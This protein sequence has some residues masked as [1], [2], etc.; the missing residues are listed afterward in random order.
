MP[1]RDDL[2]SICIVGSGPIVIGQACRVRLRRLPG[3]EGAA[4]GRLPHDRRQLEPGHDH[5]RPRLRRPHVP[6]AARPRG[7]RRGAAARAA[8]RAAADDGR[9]DGP[10]PR[11]RARDRRRPRRARR[12]ADRGGA[13]RDRARRGPAALQGGGRVVRAEGAAPRR[14]SPSLDELEGVGDCP[15]SSG[16]AFTLGG[17]GGGFADD[18]AR[19]CGARSEIGLAREPDRPGAR[20]G[21]GARLGRVR[22]RGRPRPRRQRRD[23]LLDREPRPDGRAHRRLGHGRAADDA[24]RRGLPG[25]ARRGDR[26]HPRGR[27]RHRRLEHPVRAQ[28]RDRRGARD[29]DEPA[30]LPL[31]RARVEGDR[32]PDREGRR[33]ARR[34]LHARRDPERPHRDDARELRADARL[35]RRQV[36]ALRV[37]EVPRRRPDARHADEVGR[38]D[39]GDRPHLRRGVPEGAPLPR[40]RRG[41]GDAVAGARRRPDGVHPFFRAE[42]ARIQ[43]ALDGA[44]GSTSR[45]SSPTTGCG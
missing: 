13:R 38:R 21:V 12:R 7:G 25:A 27:R 9:P 4:R 33:E 31:V 45:R 30:R 35:R 34:R 24:P 6:R 17:H 3:A 14:S 39:D 41:R 1:R 28:P 43:E 18:A 2:E 37:R 29:R 8:R 26:R 32:L 16:P 19:S 15:R 23:R 40:A 22:A 42:L 44:R 5:D 36:P 11:A 10:E 20:R